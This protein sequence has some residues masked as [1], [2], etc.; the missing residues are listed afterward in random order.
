MV[1]GNDTFRLTFNSNY[2]FI[3]HHSEVWFWY[4][5]LEIC[6]RGYSRSSKLVPFDNLPRVFH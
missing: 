6:D 4:S 3:L 5:D 1:T 2:G